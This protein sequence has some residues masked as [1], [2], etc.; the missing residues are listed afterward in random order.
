MHDECYE[1]EVEPS[2]QLLEGKRFYNKSNGTDDNAR[3]DIKTKGLWG[4]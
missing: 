1:V 2:L 4:C 3:L